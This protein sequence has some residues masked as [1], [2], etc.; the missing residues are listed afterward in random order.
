MHPAFRHPDGSTRLRYLWDQNSP[1]PLATTGIPGPFWLGRLFDAT[2]INDALGTTNPYFALDYNPTA[3]LY[4]DK[5]PVHGT[6]VLSVAAGSHAK[7]VP[8]GVAPGA[9]L[10]FVHLR[11]NAVPTSTSASN[12]WTVLAAVLWIF[13]QADQDNQP[14][15]VNLSIGT[16]RGPHDG[17]TILELAFDWLLNHP[18]RTIVVPAGNAHDAHLHAN[19]TITAGGDWSIRWRFK[20]GDTTVNALDIWYESPTLA[21]TLLT[22]VIAPDGSEFVEANPGWPMYILQ[23]GRLIGT[24]TT[25][26]WWTDAGPPF[27]QQIHIELS[28]ARVTDETWKIRLSLPMAPGQQPVTVDAWVGRDDLGADSQSSI[29]VPEADRLGTL[30]SLSCGRKTLCVGAY[31][32]IPHDQPIGEFSSAGPTRD[33]RGKPDVVAPGYQVLAANALGGQRI[34]P[35]KPE[36]YPLLAAMSGTSVSVAHVSGL[37]ALMLQTWPG[38]T[39]DQIAALIRAWTQ[40]ATPTFVPPGPPVPPRNW[41]AR[42][43]YGRIDAATTLWHQ[44]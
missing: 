9:D 15:V 17:S 5:Q 21:P 24:V 6:H 39:A 16:N 19:G 7:G 40:L 43:G 25:G 1:V 10:I 12:G 37:A 44:P 13:A 20:L 35:D 26:V 14:A 42:F 41:D 36:R 18:G 29:A 28:P 34:K 11:P 30:A 8:P 38:A 33:G 27:V 4:G 23:L 3:N 31:Y 32:E 2:T 22:T